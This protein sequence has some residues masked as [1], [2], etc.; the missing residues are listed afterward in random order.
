MANNEERRLVEGFNNYVLSKE[1]G[2]ELRAAIKDYHF[3]AAYVKY[4]STDNKPYLIIEW[5]ES[6]FTTTVRNLWLFTMVKDS[7]GKEQFKMVRDMLRVIPLGVDC[8]ENT[9]F[10]D[11]QFNSSF[12]IVR[13]IIPISSLRWYP[14]TDIKELWN[15]YDNDYEASNLGRVRNS[16]TKRVLVPADTGSGLSV[17]IHGKCVSVAKIVAT[18]F[19]TNMGT[20][21]CVEH[22]NCDKYDNRVSNLRWN[23]RAG[24]VGKDLVREKMRRA[25]LSNMYE[26]QLRKDAGLAVSTKRS[27]AARNRKKSGHISWKNY[28]LEV[29]HLDGR[30]ET[31]SYVKEYAEAY[32]INK[33]R[34]Y[35]YV[36][37]GKY[38]AGGKCRFK[39]VHK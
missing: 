10:D 31:F 32:N 35:P 15:K 8:E 6:S 11:L 37:T 3:W 29:H 20:G 27:E 30:V 36:L 33:S 39:R 34:V 16:K 12:K 25:A 13:P 4:S 24:I 14:E 19:I 1:G 2:A 28:I 18:A 26:Q 22:I 5:H 17:L 7:S 23:T 21:N 38:F 9:S